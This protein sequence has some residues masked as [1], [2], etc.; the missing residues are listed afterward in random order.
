MPR[1]DQP[2]ADDRCLTRD[3]ALRI[4]RAHQA[5]LRERFGV[6]ELAL[7][8]STVRN[9]A[10][11]DS[12]VD[13]LVTRCD[14]PNL[15]R[16]HD[17]RVYVEDL[18]GRKVDLIPHGK[19]VE[20]LRPYIEREALPVFD[21]PANWSLPVPL[22]QRWDMYV[23]NIDEACA[24]VLTFTAGMDLEQLL[25][26]GASYF[27]TL[28][29]LQN[30]GDGCKRIPRETRARHPEIPWKRIVDDRNR[31]A[32]EYYRIDHE[33]VWL[34]MTEIVPSL[35]SHLP[36]LRAEAVA[37]LPEALADLSDAESSP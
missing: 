14:R 8:G 21:P 25:D 12:D 7:F 11:P 26:S 17:L 23:D 36:A 37:A 28:H 2:A 33:E 1:R 30:I 13:I 9:E 3:E 34:L 6:T 16:Y 31:I 15:P 22:E 19:I 10:R 35:L 4:L 32:H 27:A 24:D 5:E 29:R 20:R 18:V